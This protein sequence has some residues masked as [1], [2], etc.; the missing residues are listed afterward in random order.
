MNVYIFSTYI[1]VELLSNVDK[2]FFGFFYGNRKSIEKVL[3]TIVNLKGQNNCVKRFLISRY[4]E[5]QVSLLAALQK[6][7][8]FGSQKNPIKYKAL[9][10]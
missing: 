4:K 1:N 6:D 5:K 3:T 7:T 2:F 8:I 10:L 9:F